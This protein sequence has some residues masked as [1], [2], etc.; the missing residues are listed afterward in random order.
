MIHSAQRWLKTSNETSTPRRFCLSI[1]AEIAQHEQRYTLAS[2]GRWEA[3]SPK[4]RNQIDI[5][6]LSTFFVTYM[7]NDTLASIEQAHPKLRD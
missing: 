4:P 6:D 2:V 5:D 1:D 3:A 7:K